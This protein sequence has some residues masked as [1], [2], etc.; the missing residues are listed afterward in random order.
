M[1]GLGDVALSKVS[2]VRVWGPQFGS[3]QEY[4]PVL[5]ALGG[6]ERTGGSLGL[7]TACRAQVQGETCV[8]GIKRGTER[9]T[10]SSSFRAYSWAMHLN[11]Q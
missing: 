3:L 7:L 11:T 6:G 9:L 1:V 10:L 5:L 2:D 8:K 4:N